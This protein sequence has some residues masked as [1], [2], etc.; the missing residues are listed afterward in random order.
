MAVFRLDIL[1]LVALRNRRLVQTPSRM[2]FK[3]FTKDVNLL[4]RV[5]CVIKR[6]Q[7]EYFIG[8]PTINWLPWEKIFVPV[9]TLDALM[10]ASEVILSTKVSHFDGVLGEHL[11]TYAIVS[12]RLTAVAAQGWPCRCTDYT[13]QWDGSGV[14][15]L[16]N[17][18]KR[19]Q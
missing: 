9:S 4:R 10:P 14:N 13:I 5:E 18:C 7:N 2:A 15:S 16:H 12:Q 3:P 19:Q 17:N 8:W 11:T 1:N 6:H